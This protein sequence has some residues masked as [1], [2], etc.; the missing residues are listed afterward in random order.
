MYKL[1]KRSELSG[2]V[3]L[4][5]PVIHDIKLKQEEQGNYY[6]YYITLQHTIPLLS[7]TTID[8]SIKYIIEDFDY[9]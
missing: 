6:N 9:P 3:V 8:E 5:D 2:D 1:S 4:L 7:S